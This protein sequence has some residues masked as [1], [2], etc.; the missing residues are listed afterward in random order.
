MIES[1]RR[2]LSIES[3]TE[4]GDEFDGYDDLV[5]EDYRKM[6]KPVLSS[7]R[8]SMESVTEPGDEFS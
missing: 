4:P 8:L 6:P 7:R 5:K 3:M 2:R 1:Y